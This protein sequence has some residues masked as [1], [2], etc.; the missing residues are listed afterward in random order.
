MFILQE[1][2]STTKDWYV[3]PGFQE[4]FCKSALLWL[5]TIRTGF[6]KKH[7]KLPNVFLEEQEIYFLFNQNKI[8]LNRSTF[9]KQLVIVSCT[10]CVKYKYCT[11][12]YKITIN[13][14]QI[15]HK[16]IQDHHKILRNTDCIC[17]G[18]VIKVSMIH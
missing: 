4:L 3:S 11:R 14:I 9:A 18:P 10:G 13:K 6:A 12:G 17:S 15:L 16:R 8:F 1:H 5:I 7:I 2:A